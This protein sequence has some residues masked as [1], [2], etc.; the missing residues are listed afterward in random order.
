MIF[1]SL[2]IKRLSSTS[3]SL[4]FKKHA[5]LNFDLYSP[6]HSTYG[7]LPYHC[8]EPIIFLHGIY[9]YSKSFNTDYQ[10]LSNLLHTPI[11]SVDMRCHGETENCLPFTYDALAGDLDNF[12]ITH[13]IKKPS[14]IGFSLGAKLAMLAIL[15][16]PHLYTSGVIVDNV[17]L[18]QPRIKPNLTA[19][20]NALRDSVFKSGV[21]RNDPSWISKSFNVMKDVCSDMPANFYLLHNIQPKPSYLK[22]YSTEESENSLFCKV[23]IRELSS[24]VVENVPDWPEEDLAGVKTDVPILV[25]KASTSGFVNEDGVAALEKHFSDFTIVEVAG[26]H[27][28]MKERPQEYISAVGRW[29]YQQ[30]CKKAAALTKAKKTN[31]QKITQQPILSYKKIEIA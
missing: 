17:P 15:K 21:K 13:N 16:S 18:K 11:Y 1:N 25:V 24:H 7:K 29:F 6:Q 30:N 5:K 4:P 10:Q 12:V 8:Q 9:G 26:T 20:G 2:S 31:D 14:L 19:F 28:V 27:L 23:P 3:T 22:K